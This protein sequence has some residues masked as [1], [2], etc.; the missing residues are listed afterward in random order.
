[1]CAVCNSPSST[2]QSLKPRIPYSWLSIRWRI[3]IIQADTIWF[4]IDKWLYRVANKFSDTLN[5]LFLVNCLISKFFCGNTRWK[6]VS[7]PHYLKILIKSTKHCLSYS[8]KRYLRP[9]SKITFV[10]NFDTEPWEFVSQKTLFLIQI[11]IIL[12]K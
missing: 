2:S 3:K 4:L 8:L 9:I 10:S 7:S 11:I 5:E 12:V 6:L 1:M